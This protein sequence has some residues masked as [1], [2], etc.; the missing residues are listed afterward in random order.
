MKA[1]KTGALKAQRATLKQATKPTGYEMFRHQRKT[2]IG[3]SRWRGGSNG[4]A[5]QAEGRRQIAW[6]FTAA[7]E[8]ENS[9]AAAK[10]SKRQLIS[11]CRGYRKQ[12]RRSQYRTRLRLRIAGSALA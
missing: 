6:R 2:A 11:A 8:T 5:N 10:P 4:A 9:A 3:A 12:R 1:S 7:L